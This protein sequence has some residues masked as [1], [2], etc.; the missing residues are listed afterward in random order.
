MLSD[1]SSI[2]QMGLFQLSPSDYEGWRETAL[3]I[4]CCQSP[5]TSSPL[6]RPCLL[7]RGHSLPFT[8]LSSLCLLFCDFIFMPECKNANEI[9]L[10]SFQSLVITALVLRV[11]IDIGNTAWKA[12]RG[13]ACNHSASSPFSLLVTVN[14]VTGSPH[15]PR[16]PS[17][18]CTFSIVSWCSYPTPQFR[19]LLLTSVS[20][21]PHLVPL[22]VMGIL[23]AV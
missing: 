4:E 10:T 3:L 15:T 2:L 18:P 1:P 5:G 12:L 17:L 22:N 20:S 14:S 7:P 13:Q 16:S 6:S 19:K 9:P 11:Q 8:Q 21:N 23:G